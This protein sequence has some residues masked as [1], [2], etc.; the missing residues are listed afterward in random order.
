MRDVDALKIEGVWLDIY[1]GGTEVSPHD[2]HMYIDN[3]VIA[4]RYIGPIAR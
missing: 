4:R 1:H 3:V 2:Q